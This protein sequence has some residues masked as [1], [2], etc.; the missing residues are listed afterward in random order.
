MRSWQPRA[1]IARANPTCGQSENRRQKNGA[2][3]RPI[4]R[5]I[6]PPNRP[7]APGKGTGAGGVPVAVCTVTA[8]GYIGAGG[9]RRNELKS[10]APGGVGK[11]PDPRIKLPSAGSGKRVDNRIGL[12]PDP[13]GIAVNPVCHRETPPTS[14]AT[15]RKPVKRDTR[16]IG[17]LPYL[18]TTIRSVDRNPC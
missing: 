9:E 3:P 18:N 7:K 13:G 12:V 6:A 11:P 5:P 15:I 14:C 1:Q 2:A 16:R 17:H 8:T 4:N 10:K